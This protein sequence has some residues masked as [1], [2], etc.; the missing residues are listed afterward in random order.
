MRPTRIVLLV[1][2]FLTLLAHPGSGQA[3]AV[4]TGRILGMVVDA[5]SGT[6][7]SA[8]QVRLVELGR[9]DLSHRGGEFHFERINPGTYTISAQRLGYAPGEATVRVLAG[10]TARVTLSLNPSAIE[11]EA[12]VVTGTGRARRIDETYRPTSV[13][14]GAALRRQLG[15]S[16]AA[17]IDREPG[18]AQRYN[19]PAAAQPVIRGLSGD[20]VLVLEDGN[21]TGDIASTAS[22]HAVTI[23]PLTAERIEV[24]RGPAGLLYGSNALGGVINVIRED[25]PRTLPERLT[26]SASAQAESV[27]QGLTAGASVIAPIGAMAARAELSL[28][29]AGETRTPLGPLPSTEMEGY[30]AGAGASWVHHHGFMGAAVRDYGMTYGVPGTFLG[31]TIPGAHEGGVSIDLRRSTARI[32]AAWLHDSGLFRS[33]EATGNYVRFEQ[34]EFEPGGFVGTRFGQLTG[35]ANVLA[36]HEHQNGGLRMEG[37][38]GAWMMGRDFSVGGGATGSHPA[39]QVAIAGFIYEEFGWGPLGVEVGGRYDWT[40][41]DPEIREGTSAADVRKR[42]FGAVS[43]SV[44]ATYEVQPGVRVGGSVARAFR[45]P[46]IEEL[47]SAGPHLADFSFNVGNP[48][49]GSEFGLGTDLFVRVSRAT[50]R[51]DASIFR[52]S[53]RNYIYYEPT[54]ELDP[55]LNRFPVYRAAADDAVLIGAEG[56]AQWELYRGFVLDGGASYVRGHRTDGDE[57]LPAIPPLTGSLEG[58]WEGVRYSLGLGWRGAAE[59]SRVAFPERPTSGYSLF[60]ASAGLRW[61]AWARMHTLTLGVD[62]LTDVAWR[63][64]LSRIK[65]V[66]PQPGRNVQL[67]YRVNF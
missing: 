53:I 11:L 39:T 42:D 8:T 29:R 67:L 50:V 21:R 17:T 61:T 30:N 55:R 12:L 34:T 66:A 4:G 1:L 31:E 26:G 41:I 57:P 59:Q 45:T 24:V 35:T 19:G 62:N 60:N 15:S 2:G 32:D 27:N 25:V 16:V 47:F 37:A 52:N 64:H 43:G 10:E 5:Q 33:V 14:D 23:D 54:G 56:R 20:R 44:A 51:F 46:T 40:T 13:V 48:N 3:P 38:I 65:D 49:L 6:P 63:D 28:R 36:R 18:I 58:R 7:L 9:A 22:D